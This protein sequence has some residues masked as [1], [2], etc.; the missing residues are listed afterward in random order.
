SGEEWL[1][2]KIE[3]L[4][5]GLTQLD[6]FQSARDAEA[7]G[8]FKRA[9]DLYGKALA[10]GPRED[11][12]VK[13][14]CCLIRAGNHKEA[15][16]ALEDLQAIFPQGEQWQAEM[17]SDQSLKYDYGFAL[18]GAGRYYDCLNIWDYIESIDS[19]F[20]D[21]KEFV[22]NL[23]EADL[24]Q[25]FNN[26]EDYKRIFEEGRYLQD[27]IERDSVGDLVKHCKY[28]L[29]DRLWEEERYEDI[30]ELLIP[31][32]EQMDAHL[33]ALYA[34]TFFKIA[35]LSAEHLTGLR[36]FWLSAMYD[37]EIVKEFSARNEVRG[38]VQKILIL[39]AEEL[40]K[41]YD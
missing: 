18:A 35:E 14:A 3:Q 1:K 24:Y 23:L 19:G 38:E 37:S 21:Q 25:R 5:G 31:Y 15:A 9:A 2:E 22:R 16:K 4:K 8:H 7:E 36:M 32:P 13:R 40:I 12:V 20:S 41:K 27:L 6:S 33:L 30:R 26:G 17:L 39:E 11:I 28:A 10:A 29:I 34:K